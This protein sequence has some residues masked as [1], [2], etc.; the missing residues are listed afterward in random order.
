MSYPIQGWPSQ[1]EDMQVG[2]L[3]LDS[4]LIDKPA[5]SL[6]MRCDTNEFS[7]V[8]IHQGDLLIVE[9]GRE[10]KTGDLVVCAVDGEF[11]IGF[12]DVE[13]GQ[14]ATATE[15]LALCGPAAF[16]IEGV[17]IRS[18]RCWHPIPELS[19]SSCGL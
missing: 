3:S 8:G 15:R 5:A 14:L 18:I 6:F 1:A 9:R 12:L 17:V 13:A 19:P 11:R 10:A 7:T 16:A 4:L 2:V